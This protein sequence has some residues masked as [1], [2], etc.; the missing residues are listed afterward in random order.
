MPI[1]ETVVKLRDLDPIVE[2]VE[3][4]NGEVVGIW[5][6]DAGAKQLY[7]ECLADPT[8]EAKANAF[9]ARLMP[10]ATEAGLASLTPVMTSYVIARATKN[11]ELAEALLGESSG[12]IVRTANATNDSPPET[13]T[14]TSA[15]E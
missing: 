8:N 14:A 1:V 2:W 9:V 5:P 10:N 3:L 13:G 11:I 15:T 4:A 7:D 12:A 6:A